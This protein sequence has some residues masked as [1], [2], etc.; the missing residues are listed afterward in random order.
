[1]FMRTYDEWRSTPELRQN[2]AYRSFLVAHQGF[3][4]VNP[5]LKVF[6]EEDRPCK[7]WAVLDE[8]GR[9]SCRERV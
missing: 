1:M 6:D 4:V 5:F 7:R 3:A 2:P 8:I 9:A